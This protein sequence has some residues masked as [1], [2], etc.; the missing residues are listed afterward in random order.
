[1]ATVRLTRMWWLCNSLAIRTCQMTMHPVLYTYADNI[2]IMVLKL[3]HVY[4][5]LDIYAMH[6]I[7]SIYHGQCNIASICDQL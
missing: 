1:M 7:N 3:D 2:N 5:Y 6:G 4:R